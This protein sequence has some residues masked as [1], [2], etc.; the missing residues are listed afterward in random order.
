MEKSEFEK[1]TVFFGAGQK[2]MK[3]VIHTWK[4]NIFILYIIAL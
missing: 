2:E 4:H 3:K 1:N